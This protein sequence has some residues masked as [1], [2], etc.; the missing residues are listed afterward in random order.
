MYI[1]HPLSLIIAIIPKKI[2]SGNGGLVSF[3]LKDES[4]NALKKFYDREF[5]SIIKAP[6]IGSNQT[7]ICPYTLLKNYFFTDEE[8]KEIN[9][10]RH[11]ILVSAGCETEVDSILN[12]LDLALKRNNN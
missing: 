8:P 11:R 3:T 5:L 12:D 1:I 4:E 9:L 7:L 2:L 6:S 10:P